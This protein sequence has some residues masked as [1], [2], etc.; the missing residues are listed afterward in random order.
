VGVEFKYEILSG[1]NPVEVEE[2]FRD[3]CASHEGSDK[4]MG[5]GWM[6]TM[7]R[8]PPHINRIIVIPSTRLTFTGEEDICQKVIMTYRKKFMRGGA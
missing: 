2:Y 7:E 8:L 1:I 4:Y 6:V 5:Q 3:I